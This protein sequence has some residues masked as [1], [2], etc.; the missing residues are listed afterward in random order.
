MVKS[1]GIAECCIIGYIKEKNVRGRRQI[2]VA[3]DLTVNSIYTDL[4]IGAFGLANIE[5]RTE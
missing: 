5:K 3:D 2:Q 4:K 1:C